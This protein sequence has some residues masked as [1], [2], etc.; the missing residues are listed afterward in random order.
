M[1]ILLPDGQRY[2]Y[3]LEQNLINVLH[4]CIERF[5]LLTSQSCDMT[6]KIQLTPVLLLFLFTI[7]LRPAEV[8][9]AAAAVAV[10]HN[11]AALKKLFFVGVL[12]LQA[13][14]NLSN[15]TST[16]LNFT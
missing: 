9:S 10:P 15:R 6:T 3:L 8:G 4:L 16:L 14:I 5:S 2:G 1:Q 12:M 11:T 13:I 7:I